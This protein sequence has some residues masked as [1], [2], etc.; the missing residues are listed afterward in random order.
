ME[1]RKDFPYQSLGLR[2]LASRGDLVI[3]RVLSRQGDYIRVDIADRFEALL[4]YYDFEGATK[5]NRPRLDTDS[6]IYAKVERANPHM[7]TILTCKSVENKK[8]WSS[9]EAKFGPLTGGLVFEC[10]IGLCQMLLREEG[11]KILREIGKMTSYEIVVGYNGRI[12]IN[13]KSST[14]TIL[15]YNTLIKLDVMTSEEISELL[16]KLGGVLRAK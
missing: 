14:A 10:P 13:S 12:W 16:N 8:S 7:N 6:I 1:G 15:I 2:Y 4:Q 9:G 3:G 11:E 5:K